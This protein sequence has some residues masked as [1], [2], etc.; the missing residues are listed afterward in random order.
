MNH[1]NRGSWGKEIKSSSC[2]SSL[3][4]TIPIITQAVDL[5]T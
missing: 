5:V 4:H 3:V 2:P 1:Q